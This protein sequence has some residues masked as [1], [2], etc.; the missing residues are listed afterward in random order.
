MCPVNGC[1]YKERPFT[2]QTSNRDYI[3]SFHG[4]PMK[5]DV[6][7]AFIEIIKSTQRIYY[8][9]FGNHNHAKPP[10]TRVRIPDHCKE[11]YLEQVRREGPAKVGCNLICYFH[12]HHHIAVQIRFQVQTSSSNPSK[13]SGPKIC[14]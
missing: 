1:V 7:Q 5:N 13:V 2:R 14:G 6:C 3:C 12:S 10:L 11:E 9:H 8:T 4:Q